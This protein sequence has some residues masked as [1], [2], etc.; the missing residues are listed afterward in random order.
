MQAI[1]V[2]SQADPKLRRLI[3]QAGPF[4]LSPRRRSPFEA[5][6]SAVAYQ[7]LHAKAAETILGRFKALYRPRRFPRPEDIVATSIPKLRGCGFSRAKVAAI[8]DIAAHT[9]SGVVPTLRHAD[10]L[11]DAEI[12][13]R[14]TAIRGVGVWTVEMFL[15]FTLGRMDVLPATDYGVRQGFAITYGWKALPTPKQLL[16]HG[17]CWRPYRSVASWYMW[18]AVDGT[19]K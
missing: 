16:A 4:T 14:L 15:M 8:R 12:I 13:D 18:R 9:L 1:R 2:L 11:S 3:M 19:A 6:V 10:A 5:L 17:E 7:Q